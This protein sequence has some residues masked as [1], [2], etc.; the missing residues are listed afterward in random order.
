MFVASEMASI[1]NMILRGLNSIVQ[2]GPHVPDARQPGYHAQDVSDFLVYVTAWCDTLEHHHNVEHSTLF[3]HIEQMAEVPDLMDE[4]E[5]QHE[6]FS[7]GLYYLKEYAETAVDRPYLYR[8]RT[9]NKMIMD[10]APALT[11]HLHD[12]IDFLLSMNKFDC[13][14]LRRCWLEAQKVAV[15]FEDDKVKYKVLP[16]VLGNSDRSYENGNNFPHLSTSTRCAVKLYFSG[17]HRGAWRFNSCDFHGRPVPLA[18]LPENRE[19]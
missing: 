8:W 1:H 15:Q 11:H 17:K 13:E 3:P 19:D 4:M 9:M 18:M 6:E 16:F 14:G 12:E 5:E 7:L 10:F 2:Q